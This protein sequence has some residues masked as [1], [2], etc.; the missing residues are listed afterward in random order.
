M[1]DDALVL[2]GQAMASLLLAFH[3]LFVPA[4]AF[5]GIALIVKGT[6]AIAA[7]RRALP[8]TGV[9]LS[10]M[11]VNV[12]TLPLIGMLAAGM[13]DAFAWRLIDPGLWE[14]LPLP[15][16]ALAAVLFGDVLGYWRHRFE[17]SPLLWPAHAVH[18]SDTR[19]TWLALE[20]FHPIN[21][22]TTHAIDN[23]GLLLLGFPAY[24]LIVNNLVRHYY[25]FFIHADLPWTYGRWGQVF[26]SPAMHRWHHAAD[27]RAF[28]TNYAVV[29]A[30]IDK[31][32]G[33]YRVPGPCDVPLGVTDDMGRGCLAQLAY[34]FR[35]R[36]YRRLLRWL[37]E[38][39]PGRRPAKNRL[40]KNAR[41]GNTRSGNARPG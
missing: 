40:P 9:N 19:M 23:A 7:A 18:H 11:V 27:P 20:R 3:A 1:L 14:R 8:E 22:V 15:L 34:P 31:L 26:V 17:H 28:D 25:G 2:L 37:R 33:T 6:Q 24:A 30:F 35:P 38:M 29:F 21:R 36:A 39:A 10:L 16:V 4:V 32:F 5:A 12:L 41:S 13:E